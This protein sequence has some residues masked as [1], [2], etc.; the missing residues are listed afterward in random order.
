VVVE[1]SYDQV[2]AERFRHA[3][4]FERWRPDKEAGSCTMEQLE[5]PDGPGFH[6]VVT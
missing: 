6:D 1:I 5:R 4:R 2:T 3:T